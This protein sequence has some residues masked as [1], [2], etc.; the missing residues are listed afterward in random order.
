LS[1]G[2]HWGHDDADDAGPIFICQ[3]ANSSQESGDK[4]N[5]IEAKRFELCR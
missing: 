4:P 2:H 5:A 3:A 1:E